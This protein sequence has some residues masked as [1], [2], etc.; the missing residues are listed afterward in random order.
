[1]SERPTEREIELMGD[2][3]ALKAMLTQLMAVIAGGADLEDRLGAMQK[4]ISH[5]DLTPEGYPLAEGWGDGTRQALS[6]RVVR[7]SGQVF[8]GV[9]HTLQVW[10]AVG[11][12]D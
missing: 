7:T 8:D 12:I 5:L 4:A 9:R 1:M 11:A 2:V 3:L 10:R 6:S